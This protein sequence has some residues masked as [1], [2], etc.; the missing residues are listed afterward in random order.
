[1]VDH[2]LLFCGQF[3]SGQRLEPV[4]PEVEV[5]TG[6]GL[7]E[8][9]TRQN[10]GSNTEDLLAHGAPL[11]EPDWW[12]RLTMLTHYFT[13]ATGRRSR[14]SRQPPL[15]AAGA[16]AGFLGSAFGA[17]TADCRI[18]VITDS[19]EGRFC[20]RK[21]IPSTEIC[22]LLLSSETTK[23]R[24]FRYHSA[25][26]NSSLLASSMF[27]IWRMERLGVNDLL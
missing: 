15:S 21:S 8:R 19:G 7:R 4:A 24:C 26:F 27:S 25:K 11:F 13:D 10:E 2:R 20:S 6:R 9:K 3:A 23:P 22:I 1:M 16:L 5:R 12:L 14:R 17:L 18:M